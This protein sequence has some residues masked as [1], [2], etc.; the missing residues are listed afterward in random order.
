[1]KER[2][3]FRRVLSL[4]PEEDVVLISMNGG[5]HFAAKLVDMSNGG[6]LIY[7]GDPAVCPGEGGPYKL[8][9]ESHG[10]MFHIEGTLVR[11]QTHFLAFQFV[12]V[13]T[14]DLA[15]IRNK[16]AR[17]EILAARLCLSR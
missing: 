1:M 9:F 7:T 14:L 17:M 13:T 15:E 2:R 5:S 4:V 8:Y 3:Q 12:N 6:A 11:R 10:Q 16:L